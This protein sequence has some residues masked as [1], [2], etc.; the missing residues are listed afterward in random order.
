MHVWS[1]RRVS[2]GNAPSN[3]GDVLLG[4]DLM[5]VILVSLDYL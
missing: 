3:G 4:P 2:S 5:A 1:S